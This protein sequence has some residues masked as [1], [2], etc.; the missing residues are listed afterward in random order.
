MDRFTGME[1]DLQICGTGRESGKRPTPVVGK[2][3]NGKSS[4]NKRTRKEPIR[5]L[6]EPLN[7]CRF[8]SGIK[9][10]HNIK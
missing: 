6:P 10:N 9:I 1:K 3:P 4:L 2:K 8:S 5:H 7:S